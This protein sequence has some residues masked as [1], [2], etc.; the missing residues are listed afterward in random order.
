MA[1]ASG[2]CAL[3][4]GTQALIEDD[5]E[6]A[7]LGLAV[8]DEQH[9]FGVR[10]R[11]LLAK[12]GAIP[13]LLVLTA[14][15]I[16]RTLALAYYGDLDVSRLGARPAGR[17]RL[18]TRV[19]GEEKFPQV[20]EFMARELA[21]GRQA[22]VVVPVIEEDA[23][24]PQRAAEAEFERLRGHPELR[25]FRLELLHG[26]IKPESRRAIMEGFAGGAVHAL[27]A[28]T[29]IEVG[30]DVPNATVMVVENAERF[31]L[32]QLHQLRG[33]VGRGAHRSVC[34]L[35]AGPLAGP[36]GRARLEV[37]G[38]L[39]D[40]FAIAEEDLNLRGPGEAWGTRQSGLPRLKLAE[41]ARDRE[42]L[43]QARERARETL[44]RD[45]HLLGPESA[46][47]RAALL[48]DFAEPLELALS[49]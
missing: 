25:A 40:G 5:V 30:V 21:A 37:L 7:N 45:P 4:V 39:T 43:E 36:R 28:T 20:V 34:V 33:R 26:R 6:F 11:A 32:S 10:Q 8:V 14:T 24:R 31:G 22:Y 3:V 19:T 18:I 12:K 49:G 16:P 2:H 17:G 48:R 23:R 47:L 46:A 41:L 42:L 29:V 35:V 44:V 15:P 13:D 27:V 38:R 9:R 1:A